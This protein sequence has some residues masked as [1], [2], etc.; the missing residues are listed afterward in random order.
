M[1]VTNPNPNTT[2][3]SASRAAVDKLSRAIENTEDAFSLVWLAFIAVYQ[4][5]S[6][7]IKNQVGEMEDKLQEI[8]KLQRLRTDLKTSES[9]SVQNILSGDAIED[10]IKLLN[11]EYVPG[12][13]DDVLYK[14]YDLGDGYTMRIYH[15]DDPDTMFNELNGRV[16]SNLPEVQDAS[17]NLENGYTIQIYHEDNLEQ[18]YF[19][20]PSLGFIDVK[21]A[22]EYQ[23]NLGGW[24]S[25]ETNLGFVQAAASDVDRIT[26]DTENIIQ[27]EFITTTLGDKSIAFNLNDDNTL[28]SLTVV[29]D[30]NDVGTVFSFGTSSDPS[31]M[32]TTKKDA[33]WLE[34]KVFTEIDDEFNA[35][36][37]SDSARFKESE[38]KLEDLGLFEDGE[39]GK[40]DGEYW[41]DFIAYLDE[42]LGVGVDNNGNII[43]EDDT[44]DIISRIDD[45][46]ESM[47]SMNQ[48]DMLYLQKSFNNLNLVVTALTNIEAS[49]QRAM[50]AIANNFS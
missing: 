28:Q 31:N 30:D 50:I 43:G 25:K 16:S 36:S 37:Y 14:E 12:T 19:N 7:Q 26:S 18:S 11:T 10:D 44:K 9:N 35:R 8:E 29:D 20:S 1:T 47:N 39:Y 42:E 21:E 33:A 46:I 4:M 32:T 22:Y 40:K 2:E 15:A 3:T 6:L 34:N 49:K 27:E 38:D 41:D 45:K 17:E 24:D 23:D 5:Q 13:K 48:I